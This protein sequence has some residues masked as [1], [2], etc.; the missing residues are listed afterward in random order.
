MLGSAGCAA[1]TTTNEDVSVTVT[2]RTGVN[3][4]GG[5]TDDDSNANGGVVA[6]KIG[7]SGTFELCSGALIA[8]KVVLTARHCILKG[9]ATTVSCNEN[10]EAG[11]HGE[12]GTEH[13]PSTVAVYTGASPSFGGTPAAV[14]STI[15]APNTPSLCDSDIALVV[16]DREIEGVTPLP[17]RLDAGVVKGETIRSVGYGQNDKLLPMGTRLR[18]AGV[19]VLAKGRGV[20]PSRTALGPHEFEVG[21]SMCHGDS[22][23]PAISETTGAV[24]GVVSRGGDCNAD[25]GHIYTTTAG[26]S[27]LFDEAFAIAGGAPIH[28]DLT[29]TRP[30]GHTPSRAVDSSTEDFAAESC[31]TTKTPARGGATLVALLG[32][33]VALGTRS[34]RPRRSP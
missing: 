6:L 27:E 26:W 33:A 30:T 16:L 9:E 19:Q 8:K 25:Y 31:S 5:E 7:S 32:C 34:R 14:G 3:I 22:G 1:E 21:R 24:L 4:F 12:F 29:L 18:K 11:K 10:G 28:E 20:S 17:V 23:G 13:P 2:A 15:V